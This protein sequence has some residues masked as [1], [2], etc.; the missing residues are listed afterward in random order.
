MDWSATRISSLSITHSQQV[1]PL[2]AGVLIT[3]SG[4]YVIYMSFDIPTIM[5]SYRKCFTGPNLSLLQ[6]FVYGN[7]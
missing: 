6:E 7:V 2:A 4:I 1:A 5:E 3:T